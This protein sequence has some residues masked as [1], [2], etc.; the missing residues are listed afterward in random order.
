MVGIQSTMVGIQSNERAFQSAACLFRL[1]ACKYL[2]PPLDFRSA[3]PGCLFAG[4]V[5]LNAMAGFRTSHVV[6][7]VKS[8]NRRRDIL[9]RSP[10]SSVAHQ[11]TLGSQPTARGLETTTCSGGMS[12]PRPSSTIRRDDLAVARHS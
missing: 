12:R 6:S 4:A 8:L 10:F 11:A 1:A 3:A 2:Q 7:T 5:G 9:D